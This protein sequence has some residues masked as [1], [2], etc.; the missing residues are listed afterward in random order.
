MPIT[1]KASKFYFNMGLLTLCLVLAGFGASALR[2]GKSPTDLPLLFH[3]HATI[4]VGWYLFYLIQVSLIDNKMRKI[5]KALG[6]TSVF[7]VLAMLVTGVLMM[8]DAWE[9]S[10]TPG[11]QVSTAHLM[12]LVTTDLV[13]LSAFYT[14]GVLYRHKPLTHKHAILMTGIVISPPG[15]ARLA[16]VIECPPAFLLLYFGLIGLLM[17]HDRKATGKIHPIAWAG[18]VYMV[19]RITFVTTVSNTESWNSLMHQLFS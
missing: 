12:A 14:I 5:H 17:L 4:Y 8:S 13:A 6:Y 19:L 11:P 2:H 3:V 18:V 1:D 15:L 9:R 10:A 7:L 16:L